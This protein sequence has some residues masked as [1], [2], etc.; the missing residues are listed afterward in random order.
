LCTLY[1]HDR[2]KQTLVLCIR[3]KRCG[4]R[5]I[6]KLVLATRQLRTGWFKSRAWRKQDTCNGLR[7]SV[8]ECDPMIGCCE[9]GNKPPSCVKGGSLAHLGDCKFSRRILFHAPGYV[10]YV[11][12]AWR[13]QPDGNRRRSELGLQKPFQWKHGWRISNGITVSFVFCNYI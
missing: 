8:L 7:V 5:H 9:K 1:G 13:T 11:F 2:F 12:I 6:S 3:K 10:A 4:W